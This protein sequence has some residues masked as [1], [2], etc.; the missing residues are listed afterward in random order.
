MKIKSREFLND[1]ALSQFV[2]D[3]PI[4]A[5]CKGICCRESPG[6]CWPEDINPFDP[7][8]IVQM[9]SYERYAID[10]YEGDPRANG[11]LGRVLYVRAAVSGVADAIHPGWGGE[12]AFL[13]ETG[14]S[15]SPDKRPRQCLALV[16]QENCDCKEGFDKEAA[17]MVWIPHQNMMENVLNIVR[18]M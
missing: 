14:C 4:C 8:R 16:P 6:I 9:V 2:V 1:Y 13:T 10:W 5:E 11:D 18:E 7:D 3:S 12:C 15:L 17:A